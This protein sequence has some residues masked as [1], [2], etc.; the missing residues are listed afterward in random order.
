[1]TSIDWD[2]VQAGLERGGHRCI[3]QPYGLPSLGNPVESAFFEGE[4]S[5]RWDVPQDLIIEVAITGAFVRRTENPS[6]P[7]TVEEIRDE[8]R[9]CIEAGA[10]AIHIHVRDEDGYN[11]LDPQ[12]FAE[13]IDPLRADFPDVFFDGCL[14]CSLD[15]E[16][17]KMKEVLDAKTL[18][19]CPINPTATYVGD[20]LFAKPAPMILEKTRLILEAESTVEI[21]VYTDGD[22][23]N[24]DRYLFRSGLLEHGQFWLILPAL[25]GCSPMANPRQMADGLLRMSR[26]I[27][28]T[29]PEAKIMVCAAGRATSYLAT[30][31]TL[32]GLHIRVGMED[33]IWRWPHREDLIE[34]NL[35]ALEQAKSIAAALG[36]DV[37]TPLRYREIMGAA[38]P[39][40][41]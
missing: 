14:V 17:E 31:A 3:S 6:Q 21:A 35:Q 22:V 1:M 26:A 8:A 32:L 39:V 36:R 12:R 2:R 29:D 28:D 24:A 15:G 5:P 41:D 11:V 16:W 19:G 18:D 4:I 7:L 40:A 13:V 33:T 38:A 37:A 23:A 34:S 25:P 10:S 27:Y 30:M 20:T 9:A